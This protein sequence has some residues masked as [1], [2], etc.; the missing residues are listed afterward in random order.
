[1]GSP[2]R[3]ARPHH[4]ACD[5]VGDQRVGYHCA[6]R[7]PTGGSGDL[8]LQR[9]RRAMENDDPFGLSRFVAAQDLVFD[10]VLAE[11]H[12]G[13]KETHW[14]WFV[15]PQLRALGRS[16]T[17]NFYGI[18]S[19]DEARA[20]LRHPVLAERLARSVDAVLGVCDRSAHEIFGSP[21]DLKFRS[22]MTL[23]HEAAGDLD[24]R[25]RLALQRFF[26][27]EPDRLTL[28]L[29]GGGID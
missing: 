4:Q 10:T 21:D 12:A 7:G 28:E 20:Y 16:P 1:M 9:R 26:A 29:L 18:G 19:S 11:L 15:F 27:G 25:F 6:G 13:R 2:A 5:G 3:A 8:I 22:S 23:F 14:I 24:E 17:A